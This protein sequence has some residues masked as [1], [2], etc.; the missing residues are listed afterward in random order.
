MKS[1]RRG[2]VTS[3]VEVSGITAHGVWLF[4]GDRE[5]FLSCQDFPWFRD[6]GPGRVTTG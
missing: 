2:A 6:P 4:L 5:I 1:V 3:Q